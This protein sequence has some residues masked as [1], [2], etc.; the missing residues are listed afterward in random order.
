MWLKIEISFFFFWGQETE[1]R[2]KAHDSLMFKKKI[3]MVNNPVFLCSLL[4]SSWST[5]TLSHIYP[6][7]SIPPSTSLSQAFIIF[8]CLPPDV[9]LPS[10]LSPILSAGILLKTI[11]TNSLHHLQIFYNCPLFIRQKS[12]LIIEWKTALHKNSSL[13]RLNPQHRQTY[14]S[15]CPN[16]T[17]IFFSETLSTTLGLYSFFP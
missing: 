7:L 16:S 8:S 1:D 11:S 14:A 5:S 15:L 12:L 13:S 6:F 10:S 17:L 3:K 4:Y 2:A 9:W